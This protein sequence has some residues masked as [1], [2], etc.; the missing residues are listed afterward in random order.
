[1]IQAK[2]RIDNEWAGGFQGGIEIPI[3]NPINNGWK[4][5]IRFDQPVT[6]DVRTKTIDS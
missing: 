5:E 4:L 6:V 1:L 3:T 2:L